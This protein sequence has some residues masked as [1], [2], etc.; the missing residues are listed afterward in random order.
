MLALGEK[1]EKDEG[2]EGDEIDSSVSYSFHI[3]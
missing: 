3:S 2:K 1:E